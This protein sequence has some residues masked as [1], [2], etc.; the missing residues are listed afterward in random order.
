MLFLS[1]AYNFIDV[2]KKKMCFNYNGKKKEI[3]S[4]FIFEASLVA[5]L[6]T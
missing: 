4:E 3:Q 1:V 6:N 5:E 2:E